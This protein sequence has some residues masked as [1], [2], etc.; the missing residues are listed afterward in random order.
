[1]L[2][3][4]LC[5]LMA[6]STLAQ[7][8]E[9]FE[10]PAEPKRYWIIVEKTAAA[11]PFESAIR[12]AVFDL[13]YKGAGGEMKDGSVFEIWIYGDDT[14]IRGFVPEMLMPDNRLN[15][16][17]KASRYVQQSPS[18]GSGEMSEF[19]EHVR[20][21]AAVV[22]ETTIFFVSAPTTRLEGTTVD[23]EVNAIFEV[24]ARRMAE[25]GKPF[26]TTFRIQDGK[27]AD[28]SVS[29]SALALAVPP[30][31]PSRVSAAEREKMIADARAE[32]DAKE[33][34][35]L[36]A[37]AAETKAKM[38]A[39]E[40]ARRLARLEREKPD[41]ERAGAIIL[42][43]T[44]KKESETTLKPV[45]SEEPEPTLQLEPAA[46]GQNEIL[47]TPAPAPIT[48]TPEGVSDE[49]VVV[50]TEGASTEPVG[51]DDPQSSADNTS[52]EELAGTRQDTED[53]VAGD[54]PDPVSNDTFA[55]GAGAGG[56]GASTNPAS[57]AR[58][59]EPVDPGT[60]AVQPQTWVTAGGL[61]IMGILFFV[62]AGIL[63]WVA[64]RRT[65]SASGP[66]FITQSMQKK[67]IDRS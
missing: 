52:P 53:A 28:F 36:E 67:R 15:V 32:I 43:G 56:G 51:K 38:E 2:T 66:S 37:I 26:I 59:G 44:P 65:R 33:A 35:R 31:P 46:T 27:L 47:E 49:R 13:V 48:Q 12:Q 34:A 7:Q 8:P 6:A 1:M 18:T 11:R 16:A 25:E 50:M 41:D 54:S 4:L 42:R 19:A 61:L 55:A 57:V 58:P 63:I 45:A 23:G 9:R 64:V 20:N 60:F 39:E 30:M 5:A 14:E 29:E 40:E 62:V 10:P 21:M 3:A 22:F 17:Q 24:H